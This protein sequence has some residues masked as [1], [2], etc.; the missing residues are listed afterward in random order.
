MNASKTGLA[1]TKVLLV[2]EQLRRAVP[3]GIGTY[4]RGLVDGLGRLDDDAGTAPD[5]TLYASRP[6]PGPDPLASLPAP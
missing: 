1:T 5:V 4:V 3:G 2:A 6:G